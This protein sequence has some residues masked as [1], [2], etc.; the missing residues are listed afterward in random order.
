MTDMMMMINRNG[1]GGTTNL[2]DSIRENRENS[3]VPEEEY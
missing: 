3:N 2:G 1:S